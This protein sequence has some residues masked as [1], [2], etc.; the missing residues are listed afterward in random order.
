MNVV[1]VNFKNNSRSLSRYNNVRKN[2]CTL[3]NTDEFD[4]NILVKKIRI[5]HEKQFKSKG[6]CVEAQ[7]I[8]EELV[9]IDA[10]TR[11]QH[12]TLCD[13]FTTYPLVH[14]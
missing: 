6:D 10:I 13:K 8:I 7:M 11:Q 4:P 12:K 9:G 5:I 2:R 14:F 3:S 1:D